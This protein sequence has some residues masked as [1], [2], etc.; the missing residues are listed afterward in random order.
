MSELDREFDTVVVGGGH[1]GLTAAAYLARAGRRVAVLESRD[2]VGGFCASVDN[3][4]EAPGF[5]MNPYAADHVLTNIPPTVD[6]ELDL[7]AE[8]LRWVH[9][10]PFY[11]Y[12]DP[13]GESIV[14]WRDARRT[15]ADIRRFSPRDAQRYERFNEI[16]TDLWRTVYPYLQG[17]PKRV[18]PKAL[19]HILT[20]AAKR[21]GNLALAARMMLGSPGAIIDEWFTSRQLRAALACFAVATMSSLDEPGSGIVLSMMAVQ[22]GWGVRRPVGGNQA[23]SEALASKV[24]RHAGV[25][26]T[27]APVAEINTH[28]GAVTGVTLAGGERIAASTVVCSVDPWTMCHRLLPEGVLPEAVY[29]ELLGMSVL[30]N[31]I[32]AFKGDVAITRRPA[33]PRH[34]REDADLFSTVMLFAPDIDYVRRSTTA[35]LRGELSDEIPLWLAA[36]SVLDRTLVPPGS[37]GEALYLFLPAVPHELNGVQWGAEK[38][39]HLDRCLNIAEDYFPGLRESVIGAH[40]TSPDDLQAESGLHK[41]HLFHVDMT[42]GQF[43]PWRPTPS[44]SGYRTPISGLFH[45]G[46]GSH[47]MGTLSGWSG[48]SAARELS[49]G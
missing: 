16:M 10:D 20:N 18:R 2:T 23:F 21:R 40:V 29:T 43:G 33:M 47:P 35:G 45:S 41:G 24:R 3:V 30:R 25:V 37:E 14:F 13:D 26:R 49:R 15:V 48:R 42:L 27:G 4:A 38:D 1:N 32:S 46:A 12:L 17:H 36:P 22:H 19:G 7:A 11:S 8:G 9:P 6:D 31:N 44:L 28:A 5:V 34:R 39:K